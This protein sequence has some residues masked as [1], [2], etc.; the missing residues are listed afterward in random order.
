MQLTHVHQKSLINVIITLSS[1]IRPDNNMLHFTI[2]VTSYGRC[3]QFPCACYGK[4]SLTRFFNKLPLWSS[5]G[6]TKRMSLHGI[7]KPVGHKKCGKLLTLTHFFLKESDCSSK[8]CGVLSRKGG[9][10]QENPG[11]VIKL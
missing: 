11:K 4:A 9:K 3:L 2:Y 10:S 6:L 1:C 7:A 5:H 8:S